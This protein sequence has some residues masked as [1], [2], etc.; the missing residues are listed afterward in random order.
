MAMQADVPEDGMT[1]DPDTLESTGI[2]EMAEYNGVLLTED[3][4]VNRSNLRYARKSISSLEA[5]A[6]RR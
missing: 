4:D 5:H 3:L 1:C 6:G 2:A